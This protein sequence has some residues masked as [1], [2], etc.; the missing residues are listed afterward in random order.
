MFQVRNHHDYLSSIDIC[1]P[2]N[3][4]ASCGDTSIRIHD[5]R[6]LSEITA[7]IELEDEPKGRFEHDACES[8]ESTLQQIDS[9]LH[10]QISDHNMYITLIQFFQPPL[11]FMLEKKIYYRNRLHFN[12]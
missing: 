11:L 12:L 10:M 3:Y 2:L 7:I 9:N 1:S 8:Y 6:Q 4:A 5:L